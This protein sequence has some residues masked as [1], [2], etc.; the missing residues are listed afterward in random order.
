MQHIFVSLKQLFNN[1][2]K[3]KTTYNN[4]PQQPRL[5]FDTALF[6]FGYHKILRYLKLQNVLYG[7]VAEYREWK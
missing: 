6:A 1:I 5:Y 3:Y 2:N 4:I 7:E